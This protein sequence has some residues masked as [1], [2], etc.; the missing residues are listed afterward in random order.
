[1]VDNSIWLCAA[2]YKGLDSAQECYTDYNW[3]QRLCEACQK[4]V[5]VHHVVN[6]S[7]SIFVTPRTEWRDADGKPMEYHLDIAY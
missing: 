4:V 2:C 6:R 5:A 3:I 1:M 7:G